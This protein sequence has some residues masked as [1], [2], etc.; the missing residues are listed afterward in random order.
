M[1]F[2]WVDDLAGELVGDWDGLWVA[3]M[4]VKVA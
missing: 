2:F 3:L 4:V 1:V